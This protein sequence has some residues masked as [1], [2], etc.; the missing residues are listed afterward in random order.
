MCTSHLAQ[1]AEEY[2]Y[3][4]LILYSDPADFTVSWDGV[5][6]NGTFLPPTGVQRVT[7]W[8]DNGDR[9]TPNYPTIGK[10]LIH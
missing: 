4:G 6:P 7:L 10:Q 5:Y 1:H 8:I 3:I 9:K 2:G